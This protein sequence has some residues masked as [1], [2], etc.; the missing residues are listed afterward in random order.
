LLN[1]VKKNS[2]IEAKVRASKAFQELE[3]EIADA[4][5]TQ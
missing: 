1:Q 4:R 3:K 5:K 2:Q